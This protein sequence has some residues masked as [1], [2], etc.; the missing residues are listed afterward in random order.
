MDIGQALS[1]H[2]GFYFFQTHPCSSSDGTYP[3][4]IK[5]KFYLKHKLFCNNIANKSLTIPCD[6]LDLDNSNFH[7]IN[8]LIL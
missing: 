8:A 2:K 4:P 3:N 7:D 5:G 6:M 1:I